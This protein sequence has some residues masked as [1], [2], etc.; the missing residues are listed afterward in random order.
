MF[1]LSVLLSFLIPLNVAFKLVTLFGTFL[2]PF[3]LYLCL[4]NCNQKYPIPQLGLVGAIFFLFIEKFSI[5]GANLPSTLAGEFS[6]S[7]SLSLFFIFFGFLVRGLKEN[8][9]LV[10]NILLLSFMVISH[11]LPVVIATMTAPVLL[12]LGERNLKSYK[13]RF[14]YLAKVFLIAFCLTAF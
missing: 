3:A 9:F 13:K 4:K 7:F 10:L 11:P 12:F 14:I 8:R 5:Y 2:L 6:Y 1:I